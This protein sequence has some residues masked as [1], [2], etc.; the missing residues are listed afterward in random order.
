MK[1]TAVEF[2]VEGINKL[3]GLNIAMDEPIVELALK[4]EEQQMESCAIHFTNYAIDTVEGKKE[5]AGEKEFEKYYR[6]TFKK[7]NNHE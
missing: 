3:T 2:L 4:L 5:I 1:K 7:T 6:E